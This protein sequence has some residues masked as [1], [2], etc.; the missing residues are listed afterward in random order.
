MVP[1]AVV[2]RLVYLGTPAIA[3]P[4]LYAL[5]EAGFEIPLVVTNRDKR[6]GRGKDLD[7][8]PVKRAAQKLDIAV[9]HRVTDALEVEADLGVVVAFG[10]LI[11]PAVLDN[12]AMVNIHFSLL[13][14]W[15]GAAPLERAI[16][17][18]DTETGVCLME[19]AYELDSGGV[20]D[21]RVVP[22]PA[23]AT[24]ESLRED[25]VAAACPLLV[26]RLRAGLGEAVPQEGEITWAAKIHAGDMQV[27]FNK[28][29]VHTER[30]TRIG[31]AWTMLGRKRLVLHDVRAHDIQTGEHAR[32]LAP[33]ELSV[34]EESVHVGTS[35]GVL[36]LLRIQ[37]EGKAAMDARSWVNGARLQPGQRLGET[38]V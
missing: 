36:E 30:L 15:R 10:R 38:N 24:L 7:P 1:P 22:I 5:S 28:P 13:P 23:D 14:R 16:L 25:L 31:R 37:P 35:D 6:R 2:R 17:A 27:D 32:R 19:L 4:P 9:T 26:E 33:G 21:R 34:V 12:L 8:T 29:A 3:V 11:K 18:G 20:Y